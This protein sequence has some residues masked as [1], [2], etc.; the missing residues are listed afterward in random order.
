MTAVR[1]RLIAPLLIAAITTA[2]AC[3]R[4]GEITEHTAAPAGRSTSA[5]NKARAQRDGNRDTDRPSPSPGN[6]RQLVVA[7]D[8]LAG[9]SLSADQVTEWARRIDKKP[10]AVDDLIEA[11]VDDPVFGGELLPSLLFGA[12]V[13][14]RNYYAAPYGFVMKRTEPDERG[15]VTYYI[16]HPCKSTEAVAVRPWWQAERDILVCPDAYRPETWTIEPEKTGYHSESLLSCDSQVGSPENEVHPRC[17]CGPGLI[18][19]VRDHDHYM[20]LHASLQ[21][22]ITRTTQY[23]VDHD[24]PLETL[25][26]G[27]STWRDRNAELFRRRQQ[28]GS[29]KDSDV[30]AAL[31]DLRRWPEDGRWAARKELAPGQHAGVL[32]APQLLHWLPDRRQRQRGIF[33]IMWCEGRN[34]FGA[35]TQQVLDINRDTANLAFV[36][37]SWKRLAETPLCTNCHARLDYG[38]QFFMGYPD[39][40]AS[41][42]FVPALQRDGK[43]PLYGNDIDDVRGEA[44]LNPRGFAQLATAQP[45]FSSCMSRHLAVHVLGPDVATEHRLAIRRDL[46]KNHSFKSAMRLA[47]TMYV[48]EARRRG[49]GPT[50][51]SETASAAA[52]A[53]SGAAPDVSTSAEVAISEPLRAML[54]EHCVGCHADKT[55]Q[56]GMASLGV[57]AD[58]RGDQLPRGLLLR[59]ADQV[60]FGQMPLRPVTIDQA[61]RNALLE[62]VI[63]ALWTDEAAR[64]EARSYFIAQ[65]R[66]LPVVPID[67]ALRTVHRAA[68]VAES[69]PADWALL[70]RS[71]WVDQ[72]TFTP[73][74]AAAIGLEALR[75]CK[76]TQGQSAAGLDRCLDRAIPTEALVRGSAK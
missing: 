44:S 41:I 24:L 3:E 50:D 65:S 7:L 2:T 30:R 14:V 53:T 61:Q 75:V 49:E 11:L 17:G 35:T 9:G 12:Y 34:S 52:E 67:S 63:A 25:F 45:E 29:L 10:D 8:S 23:I 47:L 40:R 56:D 69:E 60:A 5:P 4:P 6:A 64:S 13:N 70:E 32:T 28:I 31:A 66:G 26:T 59:M 38:F 22:E 39:S 48:A 15:E 36:H 16:R 21:R 74:F 72:A 18:R 71:L 33:E 57:A 20:E 76:A 1:T 73:S 55:W 62:A 19:C 68:G 43:G 54:D 46:E 27:N 42:H 51:R 37:D 58:M